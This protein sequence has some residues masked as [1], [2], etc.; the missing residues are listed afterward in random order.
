MLRVYVIQKELLIILTKTKNI[1][2]Y[3]YT[4]STA[5][6]SLLYTSNHLI[7]ES[8]LSLWLGSSILIE[9]ACPAAAAVYP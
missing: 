7:K 1:N 5:S 8:I 9:V 6:S 2:I 4:N 3:I